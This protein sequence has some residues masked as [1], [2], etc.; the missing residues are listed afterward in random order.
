[1]QWSIGNYISSSGV[2]LWALLAPIGGVIFQGPRE[3]IPWFVAYIVM[4][5]ISAFFDYYLSFDK[6]TE[7]P[8]Q[9]ISV[10]FALNFAAMSTIV[11]LLFSFFVR[12][13]GK[14]QKEVAWQHELIS[15]E[16]E[17]SEDLLRNI[18]PAH[19]ADRL[20]K[21]QSV[22]ADGYADVTV[23]FADILG[24]TKFSEEMAPNH[25]VTPL[26]KIFS[27]FDELATKYKVEKIKTIG[28]AYMVVG[29]ITDSTDEYAAAVADMALEA[30]EFITQFETAH[31]EKM[32]VHTGISTGPIIAGVIGITKYT[33]DV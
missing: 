5:G 7:L 30:R 8:A 28:D 25:V 4:T 20:K 24:F 3:S 1:M 15:N 19:I 22:I 2:M 13:K 16:K 11:Y 26:N 32:S 18:P 29:G 9:T 17:K 14:L 12:E 10:F 33:Y 27:G 31:H 21:Q 6:G 23:M